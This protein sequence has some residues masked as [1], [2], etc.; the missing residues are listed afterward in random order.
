MI[1][2]QC[3]SVSLATAFLLL[4]IVPIINCT[5]DQMK[6]KW[7]GRLIGSGTVKHQFDLLPEQDRLNSDDGEQDAADFIDGFWKKYPHRRAS[8]FHAMRG[9]RAVDTA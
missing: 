1:Q 9:K 8:A 5:N 2:S 4:F 3:H 6:T 7:M